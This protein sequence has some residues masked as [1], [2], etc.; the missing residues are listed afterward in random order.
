MRK[1]LTLTPILLLA[2]QPLSAEPLVGAGRARQDGFSF[3]L[4]LG[5]GGMRDLGGG[6]E[7]RLETELL[8]GGLNIDLK[9]LGLDDDATFWFWGARATNRWV[10]FLFDYRTSSIKASGTADREYRFSVDGFDFAGQTLEYLIIPVNAEYEV[11]MTN[12]WI[13]A[14]VRVTP[15]H[16]NPRGRVAFTPWLHLGLQYIDFTY[17][18]DAGAT[19]D[20]EVEGRTGRVFARQGQARSRETAGIPEYGLGAEFNLRFHPP[21]E[22]GSRLV[23]GFTWKYLDFQGA[24]SRLGMDGDDF[25][26]ID[27]IYEA[28]E[29]NLYL[30]VPL[31]ER[32]DLIAGLYA[33]RVDISYTLEGDRSFDG[34]DRDVTLKYTQYGARVGFRF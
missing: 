20:V 31:N 1:Y 23:A 26:D 4:F 12:T 22:S 33:E 9:D 6:V 16:I 10:T 29:F 5:H 3:D 27:L 32:L 19:V 28:L 14:G 11:D 21:G 17:D 15:F 24:I 30:L 18:V 25:R 2:L 7:E 8:P 13:G 34:L